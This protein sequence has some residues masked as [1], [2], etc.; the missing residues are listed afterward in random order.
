MKPDLPAVKLGA[1][2]LFLVVL[3]AAC[4]HAKE[5]TSVITKAQLQDMF[6]NMEKTSQWDLSKAMLWGY[7]FTDE[8][9]SDLASAARLLE[10]QGYRVVD[11]YLSDKDEKDDPDQWWLHVE[12]VEIHTPDT[13][14]QRNKQLYAFADA[15]G[16]DAYDGMDVGPAGKDR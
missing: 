6:R 9:R 15:N 1:T 14:D 5:P 10:A 11:I 8:S 16:L 4:S 12:K 2:L 7:F 3:T 13:L